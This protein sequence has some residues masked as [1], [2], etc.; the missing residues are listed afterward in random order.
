[1]RREDNDHQTVFCKQDQCCDLQMYYGCGKSFNDCEVDE[2][3]CICINYEQM[4][5]VF[6][7]L[8]QEKKAHEYCGLQRKNSFQH[9]GEEEE[10]EYKE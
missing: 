2:E 9:G 3:E 6:N 4:E 7:Q 10:E 1:M 5:A 8:V